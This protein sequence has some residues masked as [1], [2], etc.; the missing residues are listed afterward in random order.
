MYE[1]ERKNHHHKSPQSTQNTILLYYVCN[2]LS[3]QLSQWTMEITERV[4]RCVRVPLGGLPSEM[5]CLYSVLS[6]PCSSSSSGWSIS[7]ICCTRDTA[8][9]ILQNLLGTFTVGI[10]TVLCVLW[11]QSTL[12]TVCT[13]CTSYI[14][15][16]QHFI[17]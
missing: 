2:L 9:R 6:S 14:M 13:V 4:I 8:P 12:L 15:L 5:A 17:P 3:M 11:V 10:A 7:S 16:C 1:L